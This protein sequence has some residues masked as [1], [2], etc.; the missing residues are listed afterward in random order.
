MNLS[1]VIVSFKSFHL[2]D[3]IIKNIPIEN[4]IIIVENSLD[5][6]LKNKI[7]NLYT[8]AK[9]VIPHKNLGYGGAL[10]LGISKSKGKYAI[11][12]V[13]DI[14]LGNECILEIV[15]ILNEFND[16][17]I[18]TP[19]YP[20]EG[21]YKDYPSTKNDKAKKIKILNNSLRE[22]D[23]VNGAIMILNKEKFNSKEIFDENIFLYF[24]DNDICFRVKK[25]N[26]KIYIID[27]LKFIHFGQKS[28][29]PTLQNE[30]L[31]SR[32]WHYCW[33][34]FYFYKKHFSYFFALRK[35]LPN[36][37]KAIKFCI[38]YKLKKNDLKFELHKYEFLGLI[39]AYLLK[40]S[41]YRINID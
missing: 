29:H 4:E 7:E 16:F 32:S 27:N 5:Y 38:Y 11:C 31:K 33:S 19:G 23:E 30:V 36:L 1:F 28:S 34:K 12:M 24:E 15:K 6:D 3:Q 17:T 35:T 26:E 13:A 9:V 22:V 2:L 20:D 39:N 10:N 18:L 8:N 21:I 25:N 40:K 37:I 14:K 41:S